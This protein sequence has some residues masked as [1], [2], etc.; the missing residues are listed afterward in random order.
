MLLARAYRFSWLP[1]M[2]L[3]LLSGC[4]GE[5]DEGYAQPTGPDICEE[6]ARYNNG[7]CDF[8]CATPDLDCFEIFPDHAAAQAWFTELEALF[9][10]Q[11]FREP[12]RLL[13]PDDPR[14]IKARELVERG[15]DSYRRTVPM[16]KL[17]GP[18]QLIVV[19]TPEVNAFATSFDPEGRKA[20]FA[21][22]VNSALIELDLPDHEFLAVVM[23]ELEHA[24]GLHVV[25]GTAERLHKHYQVLSGPEP[26]AFEQEDNSVAREAILG[27]NDLAKQVGDYPYDA[28][29]GVPIDI[30][31]GSDMALLLQQALVQGYAANPGGCARAVELEEALREFFFRNVSGLDYQFQIAGL[32][33][34][35]STLTTDYVQALR[36]ECLRDATFTLYDLVGA[37]VGA[38]AEEVRQNTPPEDQALVDGKHIIDAIVAYTRD[39]YQKMNL[40]EQ[41]LIAATGGDLSTLRYYTIEDAADDRSVHV[42]ADAGEPAD[43]IG[44]FFLNNSMSPDDKSLCE[45]IL[46]AGQVPP[47]GILSDIHHGNCYRAYDTRALAAREGY[48]VLAEL[49]V[50]QNPEALQAAT[51]MLRD[52]RVS[53]KGMLMRPKHSLK[54]NCDWDKILTPSHD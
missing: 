8:D 25:A 15:W 33:A 54:T 48:P 39:R 16:G 28:L 7:T 6:Q 50:N 9:A 10:A 1:M 19:E 34:E 31:N 45:S 17:I 4:S 32:E 51:A 24:V 47:Y 26:F 42:L 41:T 13:P 5:D 29:N 38:S 23:H 22:M 18:P 30:S 53:S 21:V 20:A 27:W 37:L 11:E 43:A 2:T 46:A 35:L 44:A 12:N 40:I 49:R 14:F 36:D 3:S 52:L